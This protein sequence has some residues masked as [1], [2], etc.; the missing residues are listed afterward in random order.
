MD[1]LEL[2]NIHKAFGEKIILDDISLSVPENSIFGF[3]GKN[4]A[5]KTTTM[6]L[7]LGLLKAERGQIKVA[8]EPVTYGQT[9]SNS[10]IG[11][12]PDVPE[13]Y[14]FMTAS[15]YLNFCGEI[16]GLSK[17]DIKQRSKYL[18]DL[19][20]LG[21]ESHRI[22]G[23]SRGMK[24]RLGIAQA[25]LNQ[26][27]LL[28]CD[29]PSSALDPLG[30]KEILDILKGI[31]GE[32]TV[33]FST[34]ILSDIERI[35]TDLAVLDKGKIVLKGSLADLKIAYQHHSFQVE[36]IASA[37]KAH[38]MA[39]FPGLK[40]LGG[41]FLEFNQQDL[42]EFRLLTYLAEK[43]ISF[44]KIEKQAMNLEDLFMQVVSL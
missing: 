25:L 26:P 19:V 9:A 35:C 37:D 40:D 22:K 8:G 28:I 13:F 27:K 17:Y 44:V 41:N 43:Q 23:Y 42:S 32:T 12:L 7:I 33:L 11:Y 5:G 30:R 16:T 20:G 24:Q 15:E 29:E 36:L 6:K 3:I 4:G 39:T 18:L 38:L 31:K 34:H 14:G 10:F 21:Q 1:I 2:T